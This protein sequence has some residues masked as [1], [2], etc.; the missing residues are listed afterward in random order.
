MTTSTNNMQCAYQIDKLF[1]TNYLIWN[2]KMQML[3]IRFE[4]W[5][6][7]DQIVFDPCS[8]DAT[9]QT[10]RKLRNY[11]TRFDLI[12]HCGDWQI[13]SVR[14]L[15]TSKEVWDKLKATYEQSS[16]VAQII[17]HKRFLSFSLSKSQLVHEFFENEKT[18]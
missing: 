9:L 18:F 4:F 10:T 15:Q 17:I 5:T 8:V 2:V 11:K 1:S 7:V 6:M 3:F 13:Q 16:M 14:T 12:F